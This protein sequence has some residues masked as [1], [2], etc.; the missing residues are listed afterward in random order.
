MQGPI[1]GSSAEKILVCSDQALR[2]EA[3]SLGHDREMIVLDDSD[4]IVNVHMSFLTTVE[5]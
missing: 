3:S 5:L 1:D 2:R 4:I